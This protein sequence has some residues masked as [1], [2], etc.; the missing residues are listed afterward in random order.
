MTRGLTDKE[1]LAAIVAAPRREREAAARHKEL[2]SRG[3]R[4]PAQL[5]PDEIQELCGA[6]LRQIERRA[7]G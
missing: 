3:L 7:A 1:S 4:D 5:T 6:V 2:A